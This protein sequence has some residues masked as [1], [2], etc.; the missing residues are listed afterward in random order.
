MSMV[1]ADLYEK[2]DDMH[3]E[4]TCSNDGELWFWRNTDTGEEGDCDCSCADDACAEAAHH[5]GLISD[6]EGDDRYLEDMDGDHA[7]ALA[8][9]GWGTDEDYGGYDHIERDHDEPYIPEGE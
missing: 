8:S 2:L 1:L 6:Y 3:I 5:F 7:S 9:A 4:I